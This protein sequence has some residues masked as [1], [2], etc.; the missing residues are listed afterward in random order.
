MG[1]D[2]K[3]N[4]KHLDRWYVFSDEFEVQKEYNKYEVWKKLGCLLINLSSRRYEPYMENKDYHIYWI[5][6][7]LTQLKDRDNIFLNENCDE[8]TNLSN[9]NY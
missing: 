9:E 7:A 8:Y 2:C 1:M 4:G 5:S 6:K 3:L